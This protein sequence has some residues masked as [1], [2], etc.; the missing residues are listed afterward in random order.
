VLA[1]PRAGELNAASRAYAAIT[2]ADRA[3]ANPAVPRSAPLRD[4]A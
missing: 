3:L 4:E 1:V 2:A